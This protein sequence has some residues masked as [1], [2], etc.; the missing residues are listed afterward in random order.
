MGKF[1]KKNKKNS[2]IEKLEFEINLRNMVFARLL[3]NNELSR[4]R[5]IMLLNEITE[6]LKGGDD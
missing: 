5:L 4:E 6:E 1:L 2:E 3:E